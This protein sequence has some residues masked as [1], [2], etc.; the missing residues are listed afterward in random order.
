MSFIHPF[1]GSFILFDI[2]NRLELGRQLLRSVKETW[3][4][5]LMTTILLILFNYLFAFF[6]Y[7]QFADDYGPAC[8]NLYVCLI[9][10]VDQSLK[11]GSGFYGVVDANFIGETFNLGFFSE[12]IYII[13]AQKVMLEI[14]SG[15]IIDKFS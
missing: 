12:I 7:I 13:F 1:F 9:L 14:F 4:Q 15:T 3:F 2:M 11:S 8:E 10:L 5:L 6:I